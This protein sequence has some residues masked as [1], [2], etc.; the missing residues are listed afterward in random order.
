MTKQTIISKNDHPRNRRGIVYYSD[1]GIEIGSIIIDSEKIFFIA[2]KW[3]KG[4]SRGHYTEHELLEISRE[5]DKRL[6]QLA[7]HISNGRLIELK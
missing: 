2:G 4:L 5:H 6:S 1:D 7:Q 3:S